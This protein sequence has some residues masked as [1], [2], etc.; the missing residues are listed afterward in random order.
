MSEWVVC[1]CVACSSLLL[2]GVGRVML[3][4]CQLTGCGGVAYPS[5]L[6][7]SACFIADLDVAVPALSDARV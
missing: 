5:A 4:P 3:L 7:P 2:A 6:P 1:S